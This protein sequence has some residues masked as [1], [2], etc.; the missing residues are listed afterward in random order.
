MNKLFIFLFLV[1]LPNSGSAQIELDKIAHIESSGNPDAIGDKGNSVGLYQIS[2]GLL[3]DFNRAH[4]TD[5]FHVEMRSPDIAERVA[6]WAFSSYFPAIL[7]GMDKKVTL[8]RLI[9]CYSAGC[10]ALDRKKLPL[11]TQKYLKK[12]FKD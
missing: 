11:I 12:Y 9:V 10:G 7:K 4:G 8:E 5:Y 1:I 3:R 6:N 2:R